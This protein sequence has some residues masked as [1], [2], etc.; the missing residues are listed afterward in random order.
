MNAIVVAIASTTVFLGNQRV[1]VTQGTAWA[2][3]SPAVTAHPEL[4]SAD[5]HRALGLDL[6][7]APAEQ[8]PAA[9]AP[10]A[11]LVVEQVTA[12]PGE[13]SNA[14]RLFGRGRDQ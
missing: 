5:P 7:P 14:R 10:A 1:H 3:D 13:K 8:L 12:A 4:F 6:E 11:E 9:P 2:A